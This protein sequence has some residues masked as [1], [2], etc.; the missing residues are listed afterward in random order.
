MNTCSQLRAFWPLSL[1]WIDL[2]LCMDKYKHAQS[3]VG[4][5]YFAIPNFY[6]YTIEVWEWIGNFTP[7]F[8]IG[9]ITYRRAGIKVNDDDDDDDDDDMRLISASLHSFD[10]DSSLQGSKQWSTPT[11]QAWKNKHHSNMTSVSS[12]TVYWD[13]NY[14][15]KTVVKSLCR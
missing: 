9:V 7:H 5:I 2:N 14:K 15:Y 8:I 4:W 3:S 11:C 6:G 13:S 10:M 12:S 1:A